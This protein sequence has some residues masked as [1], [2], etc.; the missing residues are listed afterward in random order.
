MFKFAI[1]SSLF[2]TRASISRD[3]NLLLQF[4]ILIIL[5][6]GVKFGKE[7]TVS[8]LKRHGNTMTLAVILN[9]VSILLVMGPSFV[10]N[11]GAVLAELSQRGFPLT[12]VHHSFGL[13]AEILGIILVFKKFGTVR[14]WMRVTAAVW[15][16]SLALGIVFY[17]WYY[18]I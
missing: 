14:V 10:E 5:L 9:A 12:L 11:L 13:I 16:V 7:K 2:G 18:V 17:V 4:I 3:L 15:F 8:S 1:M 6:V